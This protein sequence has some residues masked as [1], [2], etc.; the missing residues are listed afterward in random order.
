M[1]IEKPSYIKSDRVQISCCTLILTLFKKK[2]KSFSGTHLTI[3]SK[4]TFTSATHLATVLNTGDTATDKT[5]KLLAP[6]NTFQIEDMVR[7]E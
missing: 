6:R 2:K 4:K 1:H 7:Y 3:H 5:D